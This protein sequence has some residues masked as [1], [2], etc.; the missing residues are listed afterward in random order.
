MMDQLIGHSQR[1]F[2]LMLADVEH[3]HGLAH[4]A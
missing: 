4:V 3:G 1:P 2:R